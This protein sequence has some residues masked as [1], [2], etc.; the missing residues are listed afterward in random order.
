MQDMLD[1]KQNAGIIQDIL[2]RILKQNEQG[3]SEYDL[4]HTVKEEIFQG[5]AND[6]FRDTHKLF[7]VHFI[8]FH[9]LYCLRTAL[10]ESGHGHLEISPLNICIKPIETC[11]GQYLGKPD[12]LSEYYLDASNLEKT[13]QKDV[14]DLLNG[15]WQYLLAGEDKLSAMNILEMEEPFDVESL[16]QQYRKMVMK[17]HPDRG[18]DTGK[19]QEINEALKV[20]KRCLL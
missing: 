8:L 14:D 19:L 6:L 7:T 5:D 3:L 15:F 12:S 16:T 2:L 10:W 11:Q 20:L 18:G 1:L 9:G 4:I 13:S 17:H